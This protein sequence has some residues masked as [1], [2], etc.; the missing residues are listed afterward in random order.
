MLKFLWF[1][2]VNKDHPTVIQYHFRRLVFGLTSSPAILN[3]VLLH[4]LIQGKGN[5]SPVNC[6]L[7]ESLY[8]DYFVGG[9]VNDKEAFELYQKAREVMRKWSTNSPTLRAKMESEHRSH[10]DPSAPELKVLSL[11]WNTEDDELF[12]DVSELMTY[13]DTLAPTKRSV[14]KFSAT[15]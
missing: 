9:A 14:L 15:L 11:N 8:V 3:S 10:R 5:E 13:W 2:N 1:D 4:H 12:V 7:V 6:L